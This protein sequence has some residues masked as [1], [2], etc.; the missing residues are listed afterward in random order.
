MNKSVISQQKII[1]CMIISIMVEIAIEC[2]DWFLQLSDIAYILDIGN[3][4]MSIIIFI[5]L[6]IFVIKIIR[7]ENK[8]SKNKIISVCFNIILYIAYIKLLVEVDY[9]IQSFL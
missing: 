3:F 1:I 6:V 4:I 7:L 5:M 2:F 9:G 8:L